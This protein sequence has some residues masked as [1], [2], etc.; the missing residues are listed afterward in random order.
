MNK[1]TFAIETEN[2]DDLKVYQQAM[3]MYSAVVDILGYLRN[4]A[5]HTNDDD[6]SRDVE[7]IR[8][9]IHYIL[10]QHGVELNA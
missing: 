5:K 9:H 8:G 4:I 6:V 3:D 2:M 10:D 7:H 1:Y